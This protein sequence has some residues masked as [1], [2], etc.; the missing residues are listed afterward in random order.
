MCINYMVNIYNPFSLIKTIVL[1]ANYFLFKLILY[2]QIKNI[3]QCNNL[4]FKAKFYI[5]NNSILK[6]MQLA[7]QTTKLDTMFN[8]SCAV[9][10]LDTMSEFIKNNILCKY[11]NHP[12]N[13]ITKMLAFTQYKAVC[14]LRI[15]ADRIFL[16][17]NY[18]SI[19]QLNE[20]FVHTNTT[21]PEYINE[22]AKIGHTLKDKFLIINSED[23][24]LENLAET[25]EATIFVLNHPN[26]HKDKFIYAIIN[27][28]INKIYVKNN[29]QNSCPRPKILVSKNILKIANK[30]VLNIY[31]HLGL[32]P[33]DAEKENRF[34]LLN[35]QAMKLLL[36][37]FCM[38][39]SN[40][41]IFPEGNNSVYKNKPLK[42]KIKPGIAEIIRI[43]S[44]NKK[45]VR[46]VPIGITYVNENNNLGKIFIGKPIFFTK[47]NTQATNTQQKILDLICSKMKLCMEQSELLE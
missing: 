7:N 35:I 23:K 37:E 12:S 8:E 24:V 42:E 46:V 10:I 33:V 15:L 28:M 13:K 1:S 34:S 16:L 26:H 47:D 14:N 22:L 44:Q 27:A 4:D 2:M 29:L 45:N 19:N 41:F 11:F 3:N 6:D 40:I 39:K 9:K 31:Q 20:D 5:N 38:D 32:T 21:S 18:K 43:C 36:Q 25:N 30:K 17:S